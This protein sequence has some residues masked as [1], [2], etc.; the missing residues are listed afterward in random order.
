MSWWIVE[1]CRAVNI[2][3]PTPV[4]VN[5]IPAVLDGCDVIGCAKTGTGKTLAFALPILETLSHDPYGIYALVLTPTRELA[6]QIAEQFEILGKPLNLKTCIV[7]HVLI[8]TPG[9]LADHISSSSELNLKKIRYFVMDEADRLLDGQ[10]DNELKTIFEAL[11]QK[12]QTATVTDAIARV[13]E[14]ATSKPFFWQ[15]ESDVLT[16][17][18]LE[19]RYVLC[20][21]DVKDAYLVYVV[22]MFHERNPRSAILI[23]CHT[24]HE[25]QALCM[26]FKNLGFEVCAL[27][28]MIHQAERMKSLDRF[29]SN[30]LKIMVCTDV[31]ARGL[32]IPRV[33]LVVNHNVPLQ[34][35][36]YVHRV[37]R[38]A[39][40]GLPGKAITFVTQYDVCLIQAVEKLI[41]CKLTE[42]KISHR[43]VSQ[44]VTEV[45]V[46]KREAEVKLEANK[47]GEEREIHRRKQ[48][49]LEG[50][51]P[52]DVS[53]AIERSK[54]S[55]M[56]RSKRKIDSIKA[57]LKSKRTKRG[58]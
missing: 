40:A 52:A 39:R 45:L 12:R 38:A 55:R 15:D 54:A 16:V 48:M 47:F 36:T 49:I 56:H 17:D 42:L 24:C 33:D 22:K 29:R 31:A 7:P 32:H 51:D 41:N 30:I 4:Q 35:K 14:I 57:T 13:K 1:Q 8:A 28:S 26:M 19:Q 5:C 53:K 11:P 23:F 2:T 25:C 43:K 10:Y 20:P 9:R 6:I 50:L 58:K 37:G 21:Q 3:N 46:A 27:H 18:T 34:P 44:H